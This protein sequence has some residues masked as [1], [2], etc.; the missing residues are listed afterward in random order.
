MRRQ[1]PGQD[2]MPFF[3]EQLL[4][5]IHNNFPRILIMNVLILF[6]PSSQPFSQIISSCSG[7]TQIC[8]SGPLTPDS[9][10]QMNC[11]RSCPLQ[12]FPSLMFFRD[13]SG[14]S[15]GI[16]MLYLSTLNQNSHVVK[17]HLETRLEVFLCCFFSPQTTSHRKQ[18]WR[19]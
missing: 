3:L 10:Y 14:I 16:Q 15:S 18:P 11:S 8:T 6:F 5:P 7:I 1:G 13:S 17:T 9:E 2:V 12:R 19:L 4:L